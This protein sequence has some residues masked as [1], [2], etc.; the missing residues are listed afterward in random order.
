MRP[1]FELSAGS[2]L[3]PSCGA[4]WRLEFAHAVDQDSPLLGLG[5]GDVGLPPAD[6]I[7]GRAGFERCFF[8]LTGGRTSVEVVAK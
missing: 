3:C 4:S 7:V 6:V 8:L 2:G 5:P 1:A